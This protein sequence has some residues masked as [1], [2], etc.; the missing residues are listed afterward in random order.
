MKHASFMWN[1]WWNQIA[2]LNIFFSVHYIE[3]LKIVTFANF[4]TCDVNLRPVGKHLFRDEEP[5]VAGTKRW[6]KEADI[7]I[8]ESNISGKMKSKYGIQRCTYGVVIA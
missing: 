1:Y 6:P 7:L 8:Y 5:S 2:R 4:Q 3:H